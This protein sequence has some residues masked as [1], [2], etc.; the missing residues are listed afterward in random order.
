MGFWSHD[1]KILPVKY[2][3]E[4]IGRECGNL[5]ANLV[6]LDYKRK[7]QGLCCRK[8]VLFEN[9]QGAC[10]GSLWLEMEFECLIYR[11]CNWNVGND[12]RII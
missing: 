2:G 4:D 6:K 3:R 10:F 1:Y 11:A 7:G 12:R 9:C 8:K 5:R